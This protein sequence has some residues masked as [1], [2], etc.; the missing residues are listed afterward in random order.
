LFES[1]ENLV[2]SFLTSGGLD[3]FFEVSEDHICRDDYFDEA[4][5]TDECSVMF[6]NDD[7]GIEIDEVDSDDFLEAFCRAARNLDARGRV[8]DAEDEEYAFVSREGDPY[9]L[10]ADK[11][12]LFNDELDER[13]REEEADEE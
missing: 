11:I 2:I 13:A 1:F 7:L 4:A 6:T 10:N 9:Y 12:E 8:Y 5:D 3:E